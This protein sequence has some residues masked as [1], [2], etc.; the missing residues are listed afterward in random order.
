[1]KYIDTD[2]IHI[3]ILDDKTV[4]VEAMDGV[5]INFEKSKYANSRGSTRENS[6]FNKAGNDLGATLET[7]IQHRHRSV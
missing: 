2:F 3:S 7:G 6:I 1:M 4:L 5:D